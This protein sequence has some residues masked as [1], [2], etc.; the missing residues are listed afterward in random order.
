MQGLEVIQGAISGLHNEARQ[1]S[2]RTDL[3]RWADDT[4]GMHLWSK[5]RE[6]GESLK[7]H[8][9][10]VVASCHGAGK[11]LALD[12]IIPTPDGSTRMKDIDVGD[13]V[14]DEQGNPTTVIATS[15]I[16][17][18]DTYE[19]EFSDGTSII[20][21]GEHEWTTLDARTRN[22]LRVR[23]NRKNISIDWRDYWDWA[24]TRTTLQIA[25][26]LKNERGE[27]N[28]L[29]PN[30]RIPI[31]SL[32]E[33]HPTTRMC[34]GLGIVQDDGSV[35]LRGGP[36]SSAWI[37]HDILRRN[38]GAYYVKIVKG[39]T[40]F[41]TAWWDVIARF[42][43]SPFF[44]GSNEDD[45]WH[46]ANED[47]RFGSRTTGRTIV[48][49]RQ[50]IT[51]E[52]KCIQVDSPRNLYL[53]GE[54]MIPTHN[55]LIASIAG[56]WWNSVHPPGEAI[57]IST[58]PSHH[59]VSAI[60]WEEMRKHHAT[61]QARGMPMPGYITQSNQWKL[62]DGRII[63]MGRKPADGDAHAFQGIHRP[64]VLVLIDEAAGV[65]EELW[66]G[67][68]A[69]TTTNNSRILAI[70]NPDD[71]E[72]S[73]GDVFC[74]SRFE[75]M[76]KRIRIPAFETPNF[77]GEYV[78]EPLPDLLVQR[79]W[80]EDR[81]IAWTED[82]PRY[83]SKVLAQFPDRS[84]M[85]LFGA[86]VLARGF[87]TDDDIHGSGRLRIGVDPARFG[88]DR[89]AIVASRGKVSWVVDSWMG[90]DTVSTAQRVI[91][92]VN[93]LRKVDEEGM[94]IEFDVDIR[95]DVV[96]LGAGVVDNLAAQQA[97]LSWYTV[98]E[99]NGAAAPPI[100]QGGSTQG[101]GNARA[102]WFDQTKQ[103]M[104]NG[105]INVIPHGVLH[106][107]LAGVRF[108]YRSGK[109]YIES[110]EDMRKRGVKSPDYA[111]A[112]IYANAPILDTLEFG[113]MVSQSASDITKE[114]LLDDLAE[115]RE[116]QI[117]PY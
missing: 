49:V 10:T 109:M 24:T 2:Y 58:A 82:D 69:I 91:H 12:T 53:A 108:Q 15:P 110:K 81:R 3:V 60:L 112:F 32:Y 80:V 5:Q 92:T 14:L 102:Y 13:T 22:R 23:A 28:H 86:A 83:K 74:D 72:T 77:T 63:G 78:P 106:D 7:N 16:Y 62:N 79:S 43:E 18:F 46:A 70:G 56:C 116:N 51:T 44:D 48:A 103:S 105:L 96:G 25:D 29:I 17:F 75:H 21:S 40:N 107:E 52:T 88:D 37:I 11:A 45:E 98:R 67:V 34:E 26:S 31:G 115:Q 8:K 100:E 36:Y 59:Q 104:A 87:D 95:V 38:S 6:I 27:Y 66:T 61:A 39:S 89:T 84:V 9:R 42:P 71:R 97:K 85:S 33:N 68:E 55:S 73:F 1:A 101:Y 90:M 54:Q 113:D 76:W 93:G 35:R 19:V 114:A 20:C 41:G 4:L 50:V 111:D 117:S 30:A 47:K 64:Y 57:V 99:M 65:G 94:P